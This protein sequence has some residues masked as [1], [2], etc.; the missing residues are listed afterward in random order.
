MYDELY[1][2][3]HLAELH[4]EFEAVKLLRTWRALAASD[5]VPSGTTSARAPRAT[6]PGN[7]LRAED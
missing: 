1:L 5:R 4:R 7:P 2:E 3:A 6:R